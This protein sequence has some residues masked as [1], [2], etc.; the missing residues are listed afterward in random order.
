MTQPSQLVKEKKEEIK[1]PALDKK[2]SR[3]LKTK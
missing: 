1:L 2:A 3:V